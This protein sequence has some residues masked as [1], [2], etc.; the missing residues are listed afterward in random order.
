MISMVNDKFA[1][2]PLQDLFTSV[3]FNLQVVN[4]FKCDFI[5]FIAI[6][7]ISMQ[8]YGMQKNTGSN[9]ISVLLVKCTETVVTRC[10]GNGRV[11]TNME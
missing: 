2:K 3:E 6:F 8:W 1:A 4:N 5:V 10:Y 11:A 9:Q 7:L